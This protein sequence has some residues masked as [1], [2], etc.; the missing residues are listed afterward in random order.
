MKELMEMMSKEKPMKEESGGGLE[1]IAEQVKSYAAS[2]GMSAYDVLEKVEEMCGGEEE[3]DMGMQE[4]EGMD[5]EG[6][7]KPKADMGKK[8]LVIAMLKKKNG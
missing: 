4:D 3:D 7:E 8:A 5:D 6:E 2:S 1:A